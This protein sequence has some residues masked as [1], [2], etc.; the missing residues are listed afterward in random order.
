MRCANVVLCGQRLLTKPAETQR[1]HW[2]K[3]ATGG[4]GDT[5]LGYHDLLNPV[6]SKRLSRKLAQETSRETYM[7]RFWVWVG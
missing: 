2:E 4:W 1:R 3:I 6:C 5:L 7:K